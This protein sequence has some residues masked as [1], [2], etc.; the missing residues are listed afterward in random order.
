MARI[1][2]HLNETNAKN[3]LVFVAV[4][5]F[6]HFGDHFGYTQM[7]DNMV[8]EFFAISIEFVWDT[9]ACLIGR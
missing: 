6:Y 8:E 4:R 3:A 7:A 1:T 9:I 2:K 5:S